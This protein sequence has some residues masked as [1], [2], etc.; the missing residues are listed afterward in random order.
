MQAYQLF[1]QGQKR[2]AEA[3]S[4]IGVA[5]ALEG[6]AS[7]AVMQDKFDK[8]AQIFAW[9]DAAREEIGDQRP[10]V[11][12]ADVDRDLAT[13]RAHIDE[14]EIQNVRAEGRAMTMQQAIEFTLEETNA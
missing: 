8:A 6:M 10:P 1:V 2:F 13:I 12:Q 4:K 3:A 9:A 7:L 14:A 5:Y 11:E